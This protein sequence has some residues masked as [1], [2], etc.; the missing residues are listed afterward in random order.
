MCRMMGILGGVDRDLIHSFRKLAHRGKIK[1]PRGDDYRHHIDGW[2]V[3]YFRDGRAY[4]HKEGTDA[5][6]SYGYESLMRELQ[7]YPPSTA[8]FHVRRASDRST[9]SDA[10]AHPFG[11]SRLNKDFLFAHNGSI[12]NYDATAYR[13]MTD[14]EK[15][16]DLLL[17]GMRSTDLAGVWNATQSLKSK[18]D[19]IFG[20]GGDAPAYGSLTYILSDGKQVFA[21]RDCTEDEEYYTLF[22]GRINGLHVVASEE[23]DK[24]CTWTPL[25]I[26]EMIHI[27]KGGVERVTSKEGAGE[28]VVEPQGTDETREPVSHA[29][30]RH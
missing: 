29:A 25:G 11:G 7:A 19:N 16:F 22:Y 2:G 14:S 10:K 4:L 9:I 6:Y 28:A 8:V 17:E 12:K 23:I 24:R 15:M 26:G 13:G 3:G 18:I 5:Y 30:S 20:K 1:S 21:Y 27:S